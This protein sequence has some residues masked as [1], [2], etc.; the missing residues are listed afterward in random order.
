VLWPI[1]GLPLPDDLT[2][3]AVE[4]RLFPPPVALTRDQRP[5][6][7]SRVGGGPSR[8]EAAGR[9]AAAALGGVP[10]SAPHSYGYSRFCELYQRWQ[11]RLA[12]TMR[13]TNVAGE[14]L[15]VGYACTTV[16]I[17]DAE[18]GE[19]H[20]CQLF[21]G[22][23]CA[24]LTLTAQ[25]GAWRTHPLERLPNEGAIVRLVG[26]MLLVEPNDEWAVQRRYMSLETLE[27]M[28]D[29]PQARPGRIAA[30]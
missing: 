9:D 5:Q 29:D 2:G 11:G 27:P 6:P 20:T 3:V 12:P 23:R 28:S 19:V 16:D 22:K 21:V 17:P 8:A 25:G 15:F 10:R 7:E 26:A 24:V 13:Q 14:R 4:A 30:A 18:T 1:V